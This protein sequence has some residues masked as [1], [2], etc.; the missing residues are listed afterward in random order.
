MQSITIGLFLSLLLLSFQQ[1]N[2]QE[3]S[4]E[5]AVG[6]GA[7]GH[8]YG[9]SISM[10][11]AGNIYVTGSFRQ[12]ID[13]DPSAEVAE[14]T[15]AEGGSIF[16]QK[17]DSKGNYIWAKS[18]GGNS[19][20]S[21][22]DLEGNICLV[23][24]FRGTVDFN[25]GRGRYNLNSNGEDDI[26]IQKLDANGNLLWAKSIGGRKQD[27]ARACTMDAR[28]NI[29]II[30]FSQGT[31]DFD[32]G[33]TDYTLT[34]VEGRDF[35]IL[36]LDARG[37]FIWVK[38]MGSSLKNRAIAIDV[39]GNVY[40]TGYFWG[41]VDFDP[42]MGRMELTS[43]GGTDVFVLKLD[44]NGNF[45]WA[46]SIRGTSGDWSNSIAIGP[47]G[48]LYITGGF[49]GIADF[50]PSAAEAKLH[51][52]GIGDIFVQKLDANGNFIWV[53]SMGGAANDYG[54]AVTT[55]ISGNIYV[56]GIYQGTADFDPSN[57]ILN[58]SS[59]GDSD[60]FVHKLDKESNFLWVETFGSTAYD[61]GLSLV[62]DA[63]NAVYITGTFQDKV[64]FGERLSSNLNSASSNDIFVLKI[65]QNPPCIPSSSTLSQTVCGSY[66]AANGQVYRTSGQYVITIP[67]QAGCDSSITIN[68][69]IEQ[70]TLDPTIRQDAVNGL[71]LRSNATGRKLSY[72]WLNCSHNKAIEGETNSA[73]S[74][75]VNGQYAVE[76]SNG[77]CT[78][79]SACIEITS[80]Q[81]S[82]T[83]PALSE[84]NI[85]QNKGSFDPKT[86]N[87][88]QLEV[89]DYFQLKKLYFPADSSNITRNAQKTLNQ[90][91][92]FLQDNPNIDIEV[93]GH[94]SSAPS[95]VYCDQLSTQRA[96]S[97]AQYLLREGI[98]EKRIS[99][100]GYGK[101][102]PIADNKTQKGKQ[103]NQRVEV[104]ITGLRDN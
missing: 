89:G 68:L 55:D 67:N 92:L 39:L 63:A 21:D 25:P 13:F 81:D 54:S 19:C 57:A 53:K 51:S 5:W 71:T 93:G 44:S 56:T 86:I 18:V 85:V 8:D 73:F 95:D 70:S 62:T 7:S 41:T 32:P 100:R 42:G 52:H 97:V 78:I 64:D 102:R 65:N 88:K 59:N 40:V 61:A 24:T 94:T 6:M 33:R 58:Q 75:R 76:V 2:A 80:L 35:F 23:G 31:I 84:S 16:V 98:H 17:L 45:I 11:S 101:N 29:Y 4:L 74:P 99:Y 46:K 28:G 47:D 103:M 72:Q 3:S 27:W 82:N 50:D 91:L 34:S 1:T 14:L 77:T 96:K 49:E 60:V 48:D 37:N 69:K 30:G 10:D 38:P 79:I 87:A 66:T 104:I 9:N 26:F 15:A 83:A 20:S 36:K 22:T 12:T 43:A 90:L